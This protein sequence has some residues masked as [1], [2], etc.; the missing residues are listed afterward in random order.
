MR[1]R[2]QVVIEEDQ[3]IQLA[4]VHEVVGGTF[5]INRN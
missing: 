4:G 5:P 1:I 3:G 2:V